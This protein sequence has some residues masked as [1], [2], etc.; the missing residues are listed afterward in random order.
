MGDFSKYGYSGINFKKETAVRFRVFSKEISLSNTETMDAMLDF[1]EI[2]QLSPMDSIDGSLSAV[3]I[4]IK[5]RIN[6]AIAIIKSI[7]QSQTLPTVAMLQSLFEQQLE[8]END[9]DCFDDDVEFVE[10]KFEDIQAGEEKLIEETTVPKIRYECLE[11]KMSSLRKDFSYVLDK[12]K[13]VKSSFGKKR[14]RL[15]LTEEELEKFK[16]ILKNL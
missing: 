9:N 3:E 7:E 5:R 6:N 14:L 1:F 13:L 12:V 16:R 2:H 11:D 8:H 4:R 10:K 15:E